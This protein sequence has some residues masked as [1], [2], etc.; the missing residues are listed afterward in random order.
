MFVCVA[1][2]LL[3]GQPPLDLLVVTDAV[4]DGSGQLGLHA[5][6]PRAQVTHVL[7]QLLHRHQSL[8][9]LPHPE[10]THTPVLYIIIHIQMP[11][12][13]IVYNINL[14]IFIELTDI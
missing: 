2:Y 4:G 11:A 14:L 3:L 13:M 12:I 7:I 5:R 1:V 8:L 9:Q 10:H 6:K